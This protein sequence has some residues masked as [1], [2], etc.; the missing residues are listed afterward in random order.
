MDALNAYICEISAISEKLDVLKS[1]IVD[2]HMGVNPDSVNWG[3]VGTARHILEL[4]EEA[5]A[6]M[7][8]Q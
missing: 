1:R 8:V 4:L 6:E 2:D 7:E 3:Y 5:E